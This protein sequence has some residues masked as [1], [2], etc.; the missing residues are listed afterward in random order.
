[1]VEN[2]KQHEI[3]IRAKKLCEKFIAKVESGNARSRETYSECKELLLRIK[4][5]IEND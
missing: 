2:T 3:I 5:E 1:M 4:T